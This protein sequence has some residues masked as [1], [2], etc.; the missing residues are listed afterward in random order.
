MLDQFA[1]LSAGDKAIVVLFVVAIFGLISMMLARAV[2]VQKEYLCKSCGSV[3]KP[4]KV[5]PGSFIIELGLW[6]CFLVPGLLYSLY[7]STKRY[8]ACANCKSKDIIPKDS[9]VAVQM[10]GER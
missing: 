1:E 6:L 5:T 10:L 2:K 4:A 8:N 3:G 9:P 7:R